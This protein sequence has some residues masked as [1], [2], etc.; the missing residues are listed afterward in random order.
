MKRFLLSVSSILLIA[1][2]SFSDVLAA[3][4]PTD[5]RYVVTKSESVDIPAGVP[6]LYLHTG[7]TYS[8]SITSKDLDLSYVDKVTF[9]YDYGAMITVSGCDATIS[10]KLI[11]N[12]SGIS[13]EVYNSGT[14]YFTTSNRYR[15]YNN[16][17]PIYEPVEVNLKSLRNNSIA[18][19][20]VHFLIELSGHSRDGSGFGNSR[21]YDVGCVWIKPSFDAEVSKTVFADSIYYLNIP[22]EQYDSANYDLFNVYQNRD[23]SDDGPISTGYSP[24]APGY[25]YQTTYSTDEFDISP[26]DYLYFY[27]TGYNSD[28][29]TIQIWSKST[30]T[31]LMDINSNTLVDVESIKGQVYIKALASYIDNKDTRSVTL[32]PVHYIS[33]EKV[34]MG[35]KTPYFSGFE[36]RSDL[37]V[38]TTY[39]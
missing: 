9:Y 1:L 3:R 10:I 12:N 15:V 17:D 32:S 36:A 2:L 13:T 4:L 35:P 34:K 27:S 26:I 20:D 23:L 39:S 14:L 7:G 19:S 29:S 18:T 11:D 16:T 33:S 28:S 21:T 30:N 25:W 38:I 37:T 31:K 24:S 5:I 8:N 6:S 22:E